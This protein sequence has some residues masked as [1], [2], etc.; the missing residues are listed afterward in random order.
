[1]LEETDKPEERQAIGLLAK[2]TKAGDCMA[3]DE[4]HE[5]RKTD[6]ELKNGR[7]RFRGTRR[8]VSMCLGWSSISPFGKPKAWEKEGE[9]GEGRE[10][11]KLVCSPLRS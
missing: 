11:H 5:G 9:K 8:K 1:V 3:K 6:K 2:K 4:G 7:G 10:S